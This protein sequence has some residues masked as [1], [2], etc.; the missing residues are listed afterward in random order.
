MVIHAQVCVV[1][2]TSRLNLYTSHVSPIPKSPFVALKDSNWKN[3]MSGEHNALIKNNTWVL[4]PNPPSANVVRSIWLS[5]H[6]CHANDSQ[7]GI[8]HVGCNW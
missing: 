1:K 6:K 7:V 2:P 5:R 3:A 4:I 8:S